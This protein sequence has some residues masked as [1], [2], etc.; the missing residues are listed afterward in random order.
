MSIYRKKNTRKRGKA[1]KYFAN[2]LYRVL[3]KQLSM[4]IDKKLKQTETETETETEI[5]TRK[6][7]KKRREEEA[8]EK[9]EEE[10][11][12]EETG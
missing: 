11:E 1:T 6:K 10:E 12:A 3:K 9:R 4:V 8:V 7:R 2:H 5:E